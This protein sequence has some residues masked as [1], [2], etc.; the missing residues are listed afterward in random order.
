MVLLT[1]NVK[2]LSDDIVFSNQPDCLLIITPAEKVASTLTTN[3]PELSGKC[4]GVNG[5]WSFWIVRFYTSCFAQCLFVRRRVL[6]L[7]KCF[8]R[9]S[10][11]LKTRLMLDISSRQGNS[12]TASLGMSSFNHQR[13]QF[14]SCQRRTQPWRLHKRRFHKWFVSKILTKTA[15]GKF[16]SIASIL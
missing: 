11:D 8:K 6:T 10:A 16:Y 13:L 5:G 3:I 15:T 14:Q 12:K 1:C 7:L 9:L 2:I 4:S